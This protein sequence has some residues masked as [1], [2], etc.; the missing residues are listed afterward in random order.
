MMAWWGL[1]APAATPKPVVAR[2][3]DEVV[4]ELR[5][6]ALRER[7][8]AVGIETAG[9]TPEEFGRAIREEIATWGKVVR[10]AG[11]HAD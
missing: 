9:N 6:P 4:R 7:L 2:L 11:I 5:E 1:L 3:H 10:A 8:A